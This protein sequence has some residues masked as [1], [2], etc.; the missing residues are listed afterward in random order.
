LY[1]SSRRRSE[2]RIHTIA[3]TG[4]TTVFGVASALCQGDKTAEPSHGKTKT[5]CSHQMYDRIRSHNYRKLSV[6][7]RAIPMYEYIFS[8]RTSSP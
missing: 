8:F 6:P 5:L 4:A 7:L 1:F 3:V 2:N